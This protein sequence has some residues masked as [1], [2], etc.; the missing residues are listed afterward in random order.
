M[1]FENFLV[2][3]FRNGG[4]LW[5]ATFCCLVASIVLFPVQW[6]TLRSLGRALAV[7]A[8][9]ALVGLLVMLHEAYLSGGV[10]AWTAW[11]QASMPIGSVT[12]LSVYLPVVCAASLVALLHG[13]C[14]RDPLPEAMR[15]MRLPGGP[16]FRAWLRG[17]HLFWVGGLAVSAWMGFEASFWMVLLAGLGVLAAYPFFVTVLMPAAP[18]SSS[19]TANPAA[20]PMPPDVPSSGNERQRVVKLL[21][22]GRINAEECGELLAALGDGPGAQ[23]AP[24]PATLGR[25]LLLLGVGLVVIGFLLPWFTVDARG[26][27]NGD[28][29][30]LRGKDLVSPADLTL[31]NLVRV[32]GGDMPHGYGWVIL[33][34]GVAAAFVPRGTL[35]KWQS[36]S[37]QR[38]SVA[39]V[40]SDTGLNL[41][42][43]AVGAFLIVYLLSQNARILSAGIVVVIVG[44][45]LEVAGL[46]KDRPAGSRGP[47][48]RV[49]THTNGAPVE[50]R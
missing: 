24:K 3:Y 32:C 29:S 17:W 9:G 23:P 40:D 21:E 31:G 30:A 19:R 12:L 14:L 13:G 5:F 41:V 15:A 38:H 16:G 18:D 49:E 47:N 2:F 6:V 11:S 28:F 44:Y 34:L 50:E 42:L 35:L 27:L 7:G 26:M 37:P 22:E 46:L 4:A 8:A 25:K 20:R 10:P 33:L 1:S 43:L 39:H 48:I 36:R 45:A